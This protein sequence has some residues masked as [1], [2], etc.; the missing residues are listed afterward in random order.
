[1]F[2]FRKNRDLEFR[3]ESRE[4][5][6]RM[7]WVGLKGR[8]RL[9]H[10]FQDVGLRLRHMWHSESRLAAAKFKPTVNIIAIRL[11]K[12]VARFAATGLDLTL[13]S[14]G[15]RWRP[16]KA[17]HWPFVCHRQGMCHYDS[18]EL[19]MGKPCQRE[20]IWEWK[21]TLLF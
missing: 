12:R 13:H 7:V 3:C 5:Q 11:R 10:E 18:N 19:L 1:M 8:R 21:M 17:P 14:K 16:R 2:E 9:N 15:K 20:K 6:S 4:G